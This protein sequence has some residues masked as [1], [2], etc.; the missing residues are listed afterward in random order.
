MDENKNPLNVG[1]Y[2]GI[3]PVP[4]KSVKESG[5]TKNESQKNIKKL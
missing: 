2:S 1:N 3:D 4:T 5:N